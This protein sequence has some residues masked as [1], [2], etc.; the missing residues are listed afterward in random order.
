[1]TQTPITLVASDNLDYTI[2]V[3]VGG[4]RVEF[5][6]KPDRHP[7]T[8]QD[9]KEWIKLGWYNHCVK[10]LVIRSNT[11]VIEDE[12][13][14][15]EDVSIKNHQVKFKRRG[16]TMGIPKPH[17]TTSH[18][19]ADHQ[20]TLIAPEANRGIVYQGIRIWHDSQE[21]AREYGKQIFQANKDAQFS[22]VIVQAIE[23]F[24]PKVEIELSSTSFAKST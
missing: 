12:T 24:K 8:I 10:Y 13:F 5:F 22:L 1:M 2:T 4:R 3:I 23:E 19:D 17:N 16:N 6:I 20:F 14:K 9:V 21:S 18:P 7:R 15:P 11:I